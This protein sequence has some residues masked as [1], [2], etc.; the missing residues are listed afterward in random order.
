MLIS[1]IL[2]SIA[3]HIHAQLSIFPS[4]STAGFYC[5]WN[6]TTTEKQQILWDLNLRPASLEILL[7]GGG[8]WYKGGRELFHAPQNVLLLKFRIVPSARNKNANCGKVSDAYT[9]QMHALAGDWQLNK[10]N[11]FNKNRKY[12]CFSEINFM[13]TLAS[14][15]KIV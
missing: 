4:K 8:I 3:A 6:V 11:H 12:W 2:D 15:I 13:F 10:A 5:K 9:K 7:R 14:P 1:G